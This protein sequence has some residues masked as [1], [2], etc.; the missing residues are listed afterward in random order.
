MPRPIFPSLQDTAV[1]TQLCLS[2]SR[3]V[4]LL[5]CVRRANCSLRQH[6][7]LLRALAPMTN[8]RSALFLAFRLRLTLTV[9]VTFRTLTEFSHPRACFTQTCAESRCSIFNFVLCRMD[10]LLYNFSILTKKVNALSWPA[11]V[12]YYENKYFLLNFA[13]YPEALNKLHH[14]P[15]GRG[16]RKV[17]LRECRFQVGQERL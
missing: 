14:A 5:T 11:M 13:F 16:N 12:K 6:A 1:Q 2:L 8:S 9:P 10:L 17:H 15:I 3:K 4:G 7:H